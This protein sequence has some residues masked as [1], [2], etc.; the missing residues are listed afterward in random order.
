MRKNILILMAA[1]FVYLLLIQPFVS[2]M[3]AKP[4]AVKLGVVPRP[5]AIKIVAADHKQSVAAYLVFK[6]MV[7]FGTLVEKAENK[8]EVP[9]DYPAMSRILHSAVKLDPYNMDAYYFAQAILVWDVKQIKLANDLLEYGM[10]YRTWDFYLPFF[11]GFN[12]AYFLKDYERAAQYYKR[13][14][15]LT[16]DEL[17]VNLAGRYM[18]EAG[19]TDLAIAYLSAMVKSAKN[20]AIR[21]SFKKRLEA[22]KEVR[23]IQVAKDEYL[24]QTG[25]L[26]SSVEELV[27]K[28]FISPL[29]RDPYGGSF[30]FDDKGEVRSTSNFA[31]KPTAE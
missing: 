30:Y 9:P 1:V 19:R 28:N 5:E 10:K 3:G 24:K 8:I 22:L 2:F 4:F 12:N 17:H 13:A 7:Y 25:K 11:A 6:V 26:P 18:Y 27:N 31:S 15:E 29:P 14:G 23:R 21:K 16:G 20:D